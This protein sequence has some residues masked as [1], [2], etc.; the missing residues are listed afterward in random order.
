VLSLF[1]E[2]N[3]ICS[4][5]AW[6]RDQAYGVFPTAQDQVDDVYNEV[7]MVLGC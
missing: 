7:S 4:F 3:P 6:V 2:E 5:I 1:S